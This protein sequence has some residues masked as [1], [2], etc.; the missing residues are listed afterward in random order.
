MLV[1][2]TIVFALRLR[3]ATAR[4][5][6]FLDLLGDFDFLFVYQPIFFGKSQT[7]IQIGRYVAI[8]SAFVL[9]SAI[10]QFGNGKSELGREG[11]SGQDRSG[12]ERRGNQSEDKIASIH[13]S[14]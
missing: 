5:A 4:A 8:G 9:R 3:L 11:V 12:T 2:G 7:S 6:V 1:T 10:I 14:N 13:V